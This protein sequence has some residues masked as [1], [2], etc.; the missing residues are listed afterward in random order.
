MQKELVGIVER[1]RRPI[2]SFLQLQNEVAKAMQYPSKIS[3]MESIWGNNQKLNPETW[4]VN[5]N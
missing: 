4:L 5:G 3:F 1:E 2:A